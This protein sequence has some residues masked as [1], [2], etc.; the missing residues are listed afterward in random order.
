ML[1]NCSKHTKAEENFQDMSV[2]EDTDDHV[3]FLENLKQFQIIRAEIIVPKIHLPAQN[4]CDSITLWHVCVV[5]F[6]E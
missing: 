1:Q 3:F 2:L 4:F 5:K 6:Y